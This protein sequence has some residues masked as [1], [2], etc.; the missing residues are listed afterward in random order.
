MG[1]PKPEEKQ[2]IPDDHLE[3]W[4]THIVDR[5]NTTLTSEEAVGYTNLPTA[6]LVT[7]GNAKFDEFVASHAHKPI[8]W[9]EHFAKPAGFVSLPRKLYNP[10][11]AKN[12]EN[13]QQLA[14]QYVPVGHN[15]A[16]HIA[17]YKACA[18]A[19]RAVLQEYLSSKLKLDFIAKIKAEE[20]S[21]APTHG[22]V[23]SV[24]ELQQRVKT[25][26]TN[27]LLAKIHRIFYGSIDEDNKFRACVEYDMMLKLGIWYLPASLCTTSK[28]PTSDR[29]ASGFILSQANSTINDNYRKKFKE[30]NLGGGMSIR[31]AKERVLR[32]PGEPKRRYERFPKG[33]FV[34]ERHITGW[35]GD[36]PENE[37]DR[38]QTAA[39]QVY[40][41]IFF[42]HYQ[43][44]V[45]CVIINC[46]TFS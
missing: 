8:Y 21:R 35:E 19:I 17:S 9:E 3:F 12:G 26:P 2:K 42:C 38:N 18:L 40:C 32:I 10:N 5:G 1:E 31:K 15:A 27:S 46:L 43:L 22:N 45:V 41:S 28:K 13:L 34:R 14:A 29:P 37:L 7:K 36:Q 6:H 39:Q 16:N 4:K 20:I 23:T 11:K 24:A 44:C 30:G 25:N 33:V